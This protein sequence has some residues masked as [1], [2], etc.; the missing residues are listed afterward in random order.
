M[1][2]YVLALALLASPAF[3]DDGPFAN[4]QLNAI[5]FANVN[6][7]NNQGNAAQAECN[8]LLAILNNND[9]TCNVATVNTNQGKR[10]Q[11]RLRLQNAINAGNLGQGLQRLQQLIQ[12]GNLLADVKLLLQVATNGQCQ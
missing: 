2:K 8:R 9:A 10:K 3:A 6:F 7:A 11:A 4:C 5:T 1:K 12:G